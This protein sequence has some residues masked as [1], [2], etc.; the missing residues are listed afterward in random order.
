MLNYVSWYL[1]YTCH[2][3]IT[4]DVL[5]HSIIHALPGF[6]YYTMFTRTHLPGLAW[7]ICEWYAKIY[8]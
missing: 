6:G 5:L 8:I 2:N 1:L 3:C 7:I 4:V